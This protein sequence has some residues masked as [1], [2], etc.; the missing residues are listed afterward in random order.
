[1]EPT[2][3]IQAVIRARAQKIVN[4]FRKP[5][6]RLAA[7]RYMAT[8]GWLSTASKI[9]DQVIVDYRRTHP[10]QTYKETAASLGVH[11]STVN[12]AIVR[13]NRS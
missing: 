9:A 4:G 12:R 2:P 7:A 3:E 1:M 5:R 13:H 8:M 6:D 11:P 10:D